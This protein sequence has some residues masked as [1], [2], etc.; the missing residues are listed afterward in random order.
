MVQNA[1]ATSIHI[2]EDGIKTLDDSLKKRQKTLLAMGLK[3]P[4][5]FRLYKIHI[6]TIK[7]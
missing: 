1:N 3:Y 6:S 5:S 4:L 2:N 7:Q